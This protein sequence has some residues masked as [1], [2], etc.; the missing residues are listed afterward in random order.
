MIRGAIPGPKGSVV[1]M[2]EA[3]KSRG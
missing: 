2:R 1:V 3:V